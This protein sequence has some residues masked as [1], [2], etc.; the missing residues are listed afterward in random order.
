MSWNS[1]DDKHKKKYDRNFVSCE[2]SYE[3]DYVKKVIKEEFPYLTDS[4]IE[5]AIAHCCKSIATPRPRG[6][7]FNCLKRQL[8]GN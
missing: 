3:R 8:G 7:F 6:E 1:A 5:S 2:E 4:S